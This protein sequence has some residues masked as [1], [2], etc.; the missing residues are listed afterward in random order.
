MINMDRWGQWK[1]GLDPGGNWMSCTHLVV[2]ARVAGRRY[3]RWAAVGVGVLCIAPLPS[4]PPVAARSAGLFRSPCSASLF[5]YL[6][7]PPLRSRGGWWGA[8][9]GEGWW[10]GRRRKRRLLASLNPPLRAPNWINIE[11]G[12]LR[13]HT[14]EGL[15]PRLPCHELELASPSAGRR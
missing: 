6:S 3:H 15:Q 14:T 11:H 5:T 4:V 10:G 12:L 8:A 1:S 9:A 13:H 7:L 2:G